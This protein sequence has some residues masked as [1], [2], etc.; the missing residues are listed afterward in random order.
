MSGIATRLRGLFILG[1]LMAWPGLGAEP[2]NMIAG[3]TRRSVSITFDDLP[4]ARSSFQPELLD[5][6]KAF[7]RQNEKLLRELR[8]MKVL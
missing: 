6:P 5:D 3:N 2:F 1:T 7:I 8:K 4:A